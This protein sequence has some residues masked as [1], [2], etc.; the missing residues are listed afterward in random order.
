MEALVH[1]AIAISAALAI[2]LISGIVIAATDR[3]AR[4]YHKPGFFIA[5]FVLGILTSISEISVATNA[6]IAGVPAVSAGNLIGASVVIFLLI[7]PLFAI[8]ANGL[9]MQMVLTRRN[10]ALLLSLILLP[11]ILV[12]DGIVTRRDGLLMLLLYASLVYA[13]R[14]KESPA[15]L[16]EEAIHE[17]R[18]ELL[19]AHETLFMR[20]LHAWQRRKTSRWDFGKIIIGALLIFFAGN[21]LV[22]ESVFF[23]HYFGIPLSFIGLL[24]LSIGTNIPEIAIGVR[25]A[26]GKHDGIATG[27]YLGSAAANTL[28]FGVLSIMNG[29]FVIERSEFIPTFFVLLLGLGLFYVLYQSGK[30]LSRREGLVLLSLYILFV[31]AQSINIARIIPKVEGRENPLEKPASLTLEFLP[32]RA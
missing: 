16:A 32:P 13:V 22:D 18:E 11:C 5:F 17:V 2:W 26:F 9:P 14:K 25:C 20:V 30:V 8:T 27:D 12:L 15:T 24:L 7:I 21:I 31:L 1:G 29:P 4:R 23:S 19:H 6:T 28:I 3:V 10:L